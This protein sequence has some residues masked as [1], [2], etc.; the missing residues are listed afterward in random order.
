MQILI[1]TH[2]C[3]HAGLIGTGFSLS[4]LFIVTCKT[5]IISY[6]FLEKLREA[7]VS[8]TAFGGDGKSKSQESPESKIPTLSTRL[9][10]LFLTHLYVS[11]LFSWIWFWLWTS[12]SFP[13]VVRLNK[14][15]WYRVFN[16]GLTWKGTAVC[17][18]SLKPPDSLLLSSEAHPGPLGDLQSQVYLP[19]SRQLQPD[20][21]LC[22]KEACAVCVWK[23]GMSLLP[24][25]LV[26]QRGFGP[27]SSQFF[28]FGPPYGA[29]WPPSIL[30]SSSTEHPHSQE[31]PLREAGAREMV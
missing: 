10:C 24:T 22:E 20:P 1:Q 23:R 2:T 7:Q 27:I 16:I 3:F 30:S 31:L 9:S 12:A 15:L 21:S 11:S 14:L 5:G 28:D 29:G 8:W 25:P 19:G 17:F 4:I 26:H 18:A 6:Q 13:S